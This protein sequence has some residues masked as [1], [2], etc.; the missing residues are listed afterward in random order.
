MDLANQTQ[1]RNPLDDDLLF[2][3]QSTINFKCLNNEYSIQLDPDTIKYLTTKKKAPLSVS[4]DDEIEMRK[5]KIK[6]FE[7]F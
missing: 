4:N 3:D 7:I 1:P 2:R 6:F 5:N